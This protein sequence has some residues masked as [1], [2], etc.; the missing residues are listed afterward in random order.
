MITE[1]DKTSLWVLDQL[2]DTII[3]DTISGQSNPLDMYVIL[4]VLAD[5]FQ[6][7]INEIKPL[8]INER[9]KYGKEQVIR[10]GHEISIIE[11]RKLLSYKHDSTWESLKKELETHELLMAKVAEGAEIID[12]KTGELIQPAKVSYS[13]ET[14]R[15]TP[16]K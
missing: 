12:A 9:M 4:K 3:E 15:L 8:A 13:A 10:N 1:E 16:K 5:K 14:L 7:R 11:G 6:D 2:I